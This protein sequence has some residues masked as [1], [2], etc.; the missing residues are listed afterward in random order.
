MVN[1][2]KNARYAR[3]GDRYG[4]RLIF[5]VL[6]FLVIAFFSGWLWLGRGPTTSRLTVLINADPVWI[7]SWESRSNR[8]V[9]LKIPAAVQ[10]V[11]VHGYGQYSLEALWK[12][13]Q[14]DKTSGVLLAQS[15]EEAL[16]VSIPWYIGEKK[17]PIATADMVG[18]IFSPQ[19]IGEYLRG[20]YRTNL[21]LPVFLGLV[22]TATRKMRSDRT[23]IINFSL[24]NVLNVQAL[25]DGSVTQVV[26]PARVDF[27]LGNLF[28][29]EL[30]RQEGLSIAIYNTTKTPFLGGRLARL[31]NRMGAVVVTVGNAQGP[32]ID[33]CQLV[34]HKT[35]LTSVTANL[36]KQVLH[37]QSLETSENE[38]ADLLLKVGTAYE[39][40]FL[41]LAPQRP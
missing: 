16:G 41:P 3:L 33:R 12:L 19:G 40:R 7:W 17:A 35:Q 8:A 29:D 28:E 15:L 38:R 6:F 30:V 1:R 26:D 22:N 23:S 37:C 39:A 13:G 25:P 11:G 27:I 18:K 31:L 2:A 32:S 36:I 5:L 21:P 34:G 20:A 10:L 4:G 9:L 24:A 14:L